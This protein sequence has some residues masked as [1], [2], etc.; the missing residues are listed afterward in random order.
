MKRKSKVEEKEEEEDETDNNNRGVS[1][2]QT[3]KPVIPTKPECMPR[4]LE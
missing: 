4:G 2:G 3:A 1:A